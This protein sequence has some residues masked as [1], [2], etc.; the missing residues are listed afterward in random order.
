MY[1]D[2][3]A[4]N[5]SYKLR[6][7]TRNTILLEKQLGCNPLNIFAT[8]GQTLPTITSMVAILHASLQ[9]YQHNINLND[10][11]DIFDEWLANGHS[12]TDFMTVIMDIYKVS[13]IIP[14][15]IKPE[16]EEAK[17]A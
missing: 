4:G 1:I 7:N 17:N 9:Q 11:Y 16:E 15:D 6:L 13:G 8:D 10:A 5:K 3:E 2:F 14:E 12:S